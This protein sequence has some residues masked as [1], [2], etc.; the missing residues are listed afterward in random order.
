MRI[1]FLGTGTSVGVPMPGC[2]CTV[3]TSNDARDRRLRCSAMVEEGDT[4][5]L[6]DCG[7]DFREQMLRLD[8]CRRIDA[9]LITHEHY[10][11]VGGIDD[12]RPYCIYGDIPL[13]ADDYA[14]THLEQRLPYCWVENKYPG[15]PRL[16]LQ[17]VAPHDTFLIGQVP[18]TPLQVMHG[19]LP[20]LGYRIGNLGYITDMSTMPEEELSWLQEL[21]VLIVNALRHEPHHSHQTL[22]EALAFAERVG[23][24]DTYIIHMC[25][26][27]GLHAD[28]EAALPPHCHLAYDGLVVDVR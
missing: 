6:L 25:H 22:E 17:R 27:I 9:V 12:L 5:I 15:V 1:T 4:R 7:P 3:C 23:A 11:H 2:H 14:A 24:R 20:I 28:I 21:D 13:Y 18:V 10:D 8:F 16:V 26:H 19:C